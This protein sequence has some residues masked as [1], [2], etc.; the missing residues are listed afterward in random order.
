MLNL[1]DKF[2]SAYTIKF[3]DGKEYLIIE[4]KTGDYQFGKDARVYWYIMER[5]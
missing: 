2:A 5:E 4:W 1:Y 3:I